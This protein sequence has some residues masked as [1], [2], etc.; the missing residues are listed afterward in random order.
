MKRMEIYFYTTM[1]TIIA[2]AITIY[3][4]KKK[5]QQLK[6]KRYEET[7]NR[8][9]TTNRIVCITRD[10]AYI[11][12]RGY[13]RWKKT[14]S[15]CHRDIARKY[16]DNRSGRPF[17]RCDVHHKDRDKMNNMPSNLEILDR[18]THKHRHE[19]HVYR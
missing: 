4:I 5:I 2:S 1:I 15:L 16:C 11:D 3:I 13:L 19:H 12:S 9:E 6:K 18:G 17:Y 8:I 7:W 10:N 14:G